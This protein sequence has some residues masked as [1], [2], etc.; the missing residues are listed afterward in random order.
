VRGVTVE[1]DVRLQS[2]AS[3][4]CSWCLQSIL[5]QAKWNSWHQLSHTMGQKCVSGLRRLGF[6][7]ILQRLASDIRLGWFEYLRMP[8]W[9][10]SWDT[11]RKTL[12]DC[13]RL[14]S[15]DRTD[16]RFQLLWSVRSE[17]FAACTHGGAV[18]RD[19]EFKVG[20][21]NHVKFVCC[22]ALSHRLCQDLTWIWRNF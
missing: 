12:L 2:S 6:R 1:V 9:W 21:K 4:I 15:S 5:E 10:K 14:K 18:A 16:S 11:T 20:G 22:T 3:P 13:G 19:A 8:R 7:N 17:T